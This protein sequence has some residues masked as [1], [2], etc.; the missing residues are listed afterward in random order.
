MTTYLFVTKPEY[1]PERVEDG[2]D[3]PWWSCSSTTERGDRAL[4]YVTGVGIQYEWRVLSD[5]DQH[6]EWKYICDVEHAQTF[7]PPI[8]IG[9]VRDAVS[10]DDWAPPYQNFRGVRSITIPEEV[11]RRILALRTQSIDES[12]STSEEKPID[13][14]LVEGGPRQVIET[15]YERNPEARRRCIAHYGTACSVCGMDFEEVYGPLAKGL[16]HVHHL[17]PLSEIGEEYEV[18]PIADMRPVCPNCH[19]VI[20]LGGALRRIEEVKALLDERRR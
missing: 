2:V 13:S 20:H 4:V 3:V 8:T 14:M 10:K 7:D 18:D 11:A 1:T 5:A 9:E 19:A 12:W 15:S 16:I 6:E 17:N